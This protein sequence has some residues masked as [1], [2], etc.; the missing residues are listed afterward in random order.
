[1]IT[2]L[3]VKVMV[4][5]VMGMEE[6]G[7]SQAGTIECAAMVRGKVKELV[8]GETWEL[9]RSTMAFT[10]NG[11]TSSYTFYNTT[12]STIH[13]SWVDMFPLPRNAQLSRCRCDRN[14]LESL[15]WFMAC[16]APSDHCLTSISKTQKSTNQSKFN[17]TAAAAV[18]FV[19]NGVAFNISSL[20]FE[21]AVK[22]MTRGNFLKEISILNVIRKP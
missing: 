9:I 20:R 10:S 7:E 21:G 16:L 18:G 14:L 13:I 5:A 15:N 19:R 1:M 4:G 2:V 12:C 3:G 8:H 11:A 22:E 6:V 17:G